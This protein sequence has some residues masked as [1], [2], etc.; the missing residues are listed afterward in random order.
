MAYQDL[1]DWLQQVELFGELR[2]I[3]GADWDLEIGAIADMA[4]KESKTAPCLLFDS[5]KGYPKGYRLAVGLVNSI[6]RVALTSGM[7][8]DLPTMEFVRV[9][10]QR[11]KRLKPIPPEEVKDSPLLENVWEEKDVDILRFP[12]PRYNVGDGGRYIGT[13]HITMTR[14]PEEG[15]INLGTYRVMVHDSRR[16]G[17]YMSPGKHGRIQMEKSF[18]NDRPFPVAVSLGNDPLLFMASAFEVPYGV[19]EYDFA[20]GLKGEPVKLLR[21]GQSGLPVP[22]SAEIAIEG[23]C[24]PTERKPE[25]PLGE[26]TGYY[27]SGMR[28]EPVIHIRSVYFRNDPIMTGAPPSRPPT[29]A[30]FYKCFWRSAMI[31]DELESAGVPDVVG[32][33]CPPEGNTRLLTVVAIRQ[34]YPGHARQAGVIASQCHAAAYLGRFTI[35][36]DEDIDPADMKDVLWALTTRCDPAQDIEIFRRCWSGPLDPIIPREKKGL[37]SRAI[38]DACRPYEWLKDF[39]PSVKVPDD[40]ARRVKEKWGKA[41]LG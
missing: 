3:E 26:W 5:I 19:S 18:A 22:A 41:I 21:L 8:V 37:N 32:V 33:W 20:G 15:W 12:T 35:V 24:Y 29:E 14:D 17:L 36:V 16:L 13:G 1:R 4:R 7:P 28:D 2:R 34:R 30:S 31:W 27:A 23:E 39:P 40:L 25:G 6:K 38:I 10:R 11:I 9:W